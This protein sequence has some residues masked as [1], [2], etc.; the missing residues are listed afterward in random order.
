MADVFGK[1]IELIRSLLDGMWALFNNGTVGGAIEGMAGRLRGAFSGLNFWESGFNF[2]R[3]LLDGMWALFNNGTVGGAIS[4]MAGHLRGAFSGVGFFDTGFNFIR[5]MLDGMWA[6]FNNGT[7]GG[8][9]SQMGAAIVNAFKAAMGIGSPSTEGIAIGEN[10]AGSMIIGAERMIPDVKRAGQA[11][12]DAL[13]QSASVDLSANLAAMRGGV[14][15]PNWV[16][17]GGA[18]TVNVP[19]TMMDN[20]D[21]E[22]QRAIAKAEIDR[23]F[24][25][26]KK[27]ASRTTLTYGGVV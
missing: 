18:V 2:I 21:I 24:D 17:Q 4:G 23:Q 10:F 1:G 3:S 19:I 8:A 7:V 5:S 11:V 15:Q 25:N 13:T 12:A 6:L 27:T 9:A 22:T 20:Q 16:Y 26:L 14:R